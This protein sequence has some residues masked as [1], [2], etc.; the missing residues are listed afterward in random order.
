M[1]RLLLCASALFVACGT[2]PEDNRALGNA[3]FEDVPVPRGATYR[4]AKEKSYSYRSKNFRCGT[5]ICEVRRCCHGGWKAAYSA[6]CNTRSWLSTTRQSGHPTKIRQ[7]GPLFHPLEIL[8]ALPLNLHL[9]QV[10]FR[11]YRTSGRFPQGGLD[12]RDERDYA[13]TV[14]H[15]SQLL[16]HLDKGELAFHQR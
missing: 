5:P 10:V 15:F 2:T 1:T 8:D 9:I 4:N 11:K 7:V 6:C 16:R 3:Q 13:K 14:R 12:G